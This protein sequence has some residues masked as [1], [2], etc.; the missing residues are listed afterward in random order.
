MVTAQKHV[1]IGL[2]Q[3]DVTALHDAWLRLE[4]A[5][6]ERKAALV[7]MYHLCSEL[8]LLESRHLALVHDR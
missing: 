3:G 2:S 5:D 4:G 7:A 6:A 1:L 8:G